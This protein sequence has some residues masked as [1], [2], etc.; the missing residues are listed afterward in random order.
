MAS[1]DQTS[2][3]FLKSVSDEKV[4]YKSNDG[5]DDE[6]E[7]KYVYD[8]DVAN[9]KNIKTGDVA[10]IVDKEK[11]LGIAKIS[12]ILISNGEKERRRCPICKK[13]NT[14]Y[15]IR[16][17][18]KPIYRCNKGHEFDTPTSESINVI[19]FQAFYSESFKFPKETITVNKIR[20]YFHKNY[21]QN[22]SM[23]SLSADFFSKYFM[24]ELKELDSTFTYPS[25]EESNNFLSDLS[26]DDYIPNLND[27]RGKIWTTIKQRR[28]QTKF[29]DAIRDA[30]GDKCMVTG[31]EILDILEAAHI[32]PYLGE[33]DQRVSNGLLLRADIHILF[34]LDLIGIE[35]NSLRIHLSK[36]LII[37]EY[38]IFHGRVL[39]TGN[40]KRP[41]K[42]AL[43]VRWKTFLMG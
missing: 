24:A 15:D 42:G 5:Y 19:L 20:P 22:M 6:I 16:K 14:T 10:V 25:A 39:D 32:N 43:E 33:K 31:C 23:Q 8:S 26:D 37:N 30:Y 36:V 1:K 11:V 17:T 29:R 2:Y 7:V 12:R 4:S 27:E 13:K 28:G 9:H 41:S 40:A 21:N 3:W 38:G 34:D 18:K 35:P